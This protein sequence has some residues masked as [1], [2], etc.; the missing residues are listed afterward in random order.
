MDIGILIL[1]AGVFLGFFAQTIVGFAASMVAFPFLLS[2]YNLKE[3]TAFMAFYYVLFS[4]VLVY[5]NYKDVDKTVFKSIA[6]F[7]TAGFLAGFFILKSVNPFWLEKCLGVIVLTYALV[8]WKFKKTYHIPT[9]LNS[10]L[11]F[12]GGIIG[13]AFT[14]GSMIFALLVTNKIKNG[15]TIR[16]TLMAIFAI[17]NFLRFPFV[18]FSGILTKQI[19]TKSLLILPIFLL[20]LY[21]GNIAYKSLSERIVRYM[22]LLF[23]ML[24]GLWFII[25]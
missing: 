2:Q 8:E 20:A 17:A 3:A 21:C 22:I 4:I 18:A 16:A 5:K 25:K 13:G 7:A 12:F 10:V 19:F 23:L 24:S 15:I 9:H 14:T 6:P 11:S 1:V